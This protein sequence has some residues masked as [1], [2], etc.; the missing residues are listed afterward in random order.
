MAMQPFGTTFYMTW[1][2][3]TR[4]S[5]L[6]HWITTGAGSF[7]V[8]ID[9][10]TPDVTELKDTTDPRALNRSKDSRYFLK[11]NS[12]TDWPDRFMIRKAN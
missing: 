7:E 3:P 10:P 5:A 11:G 9:Y 6:A 12:G 4:W 2:F 1:W 8:G